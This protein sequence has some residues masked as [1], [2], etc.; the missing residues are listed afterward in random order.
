MGD[1]RGAGSISA[2]SEALLDHTP[3]NVVRDH[4]IDA[5][6]NMLKPL[7]GQVTPVTHAL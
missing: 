1:N 4:M 2:V 3:Q 6:C 7:L 5:S